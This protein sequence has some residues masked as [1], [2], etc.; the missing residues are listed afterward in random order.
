MSIRNPGLDD[1]LTPLGLAAGLF[2]VLVGLGTL[3]GTPW[4][5][6]NGLAGVLQTL[7]GL[8]AI[9]LGAGLGWFLRE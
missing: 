7:G 6:A 5:S 3:A 1:T 2:L 4:T 9:A 8:L